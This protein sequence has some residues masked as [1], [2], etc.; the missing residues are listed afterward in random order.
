MASSELRKLY[1]LHLVDAAI[2]EIR[3]TASALDPG[4]R[5]LAEIKALETELAQKAGDAKTLA[6]EQQDL[7][8]K[9]KSLDEKAQKLEKELYGG[10][11]VNPR[12]VEAHQKEIENIKR[13]R[14]QIDDRLF[15]L[16]EL[17]PAAKKVAQPYEEKIAQRKR[18]L[19][20]HQKGVLEL[21]AKLEADFKARAAQRPILAKEIS[22]S[23]LA[24]YDA[25]RHKLDGVGMTEVKDTM[26][27]SCGTHLPLKIIEAAIDGRVVVCESCHR[28]IYASEGVI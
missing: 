19:A 23:L 26:C 8:L 17:L 11:I 12:E 6:Q 1:M 2:V 27:T 21:K 18:D 5:I 28:I 9:G 16:M 24:R 4:R 7:E 15:E 13:Q 10:K 20:A 14:S 25:I 22:P 3:K